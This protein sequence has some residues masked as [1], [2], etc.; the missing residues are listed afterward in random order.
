MTDDATTWDT[1]ASLPSEGG[2]ESNRIIRRVLKKFPS[3]RRRSSDSEAGLTSSTTNMTST[4]SLVSSS[5]VGRFGFD[6]S[7]RH[8]ELRSSLGRSLDDSNR[9]EPQLEEGGGE[10]KEE[11]QGYEDEG[12]EEEGDHSDEVSSAAISTA[13]STTSSGAR[14]APMYQPPWQQQKGGGGT[15]NIAGGNNFV[16]PPSSSSSSTTPAQACSSHR[17]GEDLAGSMTLPETLTSSSTS[18]TSSKELKTSHNSSASTARIENHQS[19]ASSHTSAHN[20]SD[21]SA[22]SLFE[23]S[24]GANDFDSTFLLGSGNNNNNN[25][26]GHLGSSRAGNLLTTGDSFRR[27]PY[28]SRPF[29]NSGMSSDIS[30]LDVSTASNSNREGNRRQFNLSARSGISDVS[31][32]DVSTSNRDGSLREG[33]SHREGGG[34]NNSRVTRVGRNLLSVSDRSGASSGSR[35]VMSASERSSQASRGSGSG[36]RGI[37]CFPN[38]LSG[39]S[40]RSSSGVNTSRT[41]RT[42]GG[43]SGAPINL[44]SDHDASGGGPSAVPPVFKTQIRNASVPSSNQQIVHVDGGGDGQDISSNLGFRDNTPTRKKPVILQ[45]ILRAKSRRRNTNESEGSN[46]TTQG[47]STTTGGGGGLGR[48]ID[49]QRRKYIDFRRASDASDAS[50]RMTGFQ[51]LTA[52]LNAARR[53][54]VDDREDDDEEERPKSWPG[55][56]GSVPSGIGGGC[57][58]SPQQPA[59][60]AGGSRSGGDGGGGSSSSAAPQQQL[61]QQASSGSSS[62]RLAWSQKHRVSSDYRLASIRDLASDEMLRTDAEEGGVD[63]QTIGGD[64]DGAPPIRNSLR[65]SESRRTSRSTSIGSNFDI[66]SASEERK[67]AISDFDLSLSDTRREAELACSRSIRRLD[68]SGGREAGDGAGAMGGGG[69]G[70]GDKGSDSDDIVAEVGGTTYLK[71]SRRV[72]TMRI[73]VV[74]TFIGEYG[75]VGPACWSCLR[76]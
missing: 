15:A 16:G 2:G 38:I 24:W 71:A 13:V 59:A 28:N 10:A 66:I 8:E 47:G 63:P 49:G 32:L 72:W 46:S 12:E 25:D 40:D 44:A 6:D 50:D 74:M 29:S 41:S 42:G 4:A 52:S 51:V 37:R 23:G 60:A 22:C 27:V 69:G 5:T 7:D 56:G 75:I 14:S 17:R 20:Y 39:G 62:H 58:H 30:T 70:G 64:D 9:F 1:S 73:I 61:Q 19:L 33:G 35:G 55:R 3:D 45:G 57:S 53:R 48:Y 11:I 67:T 18:N 43:S 54:T 21:E 26:D 34:V 31:T 65:T 68:D 76:A 36:S